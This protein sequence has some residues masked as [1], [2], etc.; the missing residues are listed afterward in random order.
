[1][2][3]PSLNGLVRLLTLELESLINID[4]KIDS[5]VKFEYN[6]PVYIIPNGIKVESPEGRSLSH[7][8]GSLLLP[9]QR[10]ISAGS[11]TDR[12]I[13]AVPLTAGDVT[14]SGTSPAIR[15]PFGQGLHYVLNQP[16]WWQT[17]EQITVG[18]H[19]DKTKL[20]PASYATPKDILRIGENHKHRYFWIHAQDNGKLGFK[21]GPW[22][23]DKGELPCYEHKEIL[24]DGTSRWFFTWYGSEATLHLHDSTATIITFDP[25]VV[26]GA[27]VI[28]F[29]REGT[30][31]REHYMLVFAQEVK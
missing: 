4:T 12:N 18:D 17:G 3:L 24:K 1:M 2:E 25:K 7:Q 31:P 30:R 26:R 10:P 23:E 19:N 28:D 21:E 14:S 29:E 9:E 8:A 16:T 27:W 15:L 5:L 22:S 6:I 20:V 13:R 11:A